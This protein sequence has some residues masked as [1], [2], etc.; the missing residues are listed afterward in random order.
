MDNYTKVYL[1]VIG[2]TFCEHLIAKF[3]ENTNQHEKYKKGSMSFTQ[4]D[5][6]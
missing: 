1:D 6:G 5:L 2:K 4:L 3:E